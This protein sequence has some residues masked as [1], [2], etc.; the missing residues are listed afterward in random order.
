MTQNLL[1]I[2][3]KN[4]K[5]ELTALKTAH[6]RG[7]GLLKVY[8]E[9]LDVAPPSGSEWTYWLT[10]SVDVDLSSYPFTQFYFVPDAPLNGQPELEY[11]NNGYTIE[12][13]LQVLRIVA[14]NGDSKIAI[15]STSPIIAVSYSWSE[16]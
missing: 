14:V 7:L 2:R 8:S 12:Y 5:R 11:K 15:H 4:A 9:I 1:T 13:R 6:Q 10:V 3:L 16:S